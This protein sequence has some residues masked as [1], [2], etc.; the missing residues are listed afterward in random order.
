MADSAYDL[1]DGIDGVG[2]CA[3][4]LD[5][6]PPVVVSRTAAADM[7]D[8]LGRAAGSDCLSQST[9][10]VEGHRG[11]AFLLG[12]EFSPVEIGAGDLAVEVELRLECPDSPFGPLGVRYLF[13]GESKLTVNANASSECDEKVTVAAPYHRMLE[14]IHDEHVLLG[15]LMM[16]GHPV[17]SEIH[18]LGYLEGWISAASTASRSARSKL[19]GYAAAR[20]NEG[21]VELLDELD[22]VIDT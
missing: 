13:D 18:T 4:D 5:I 11:D 16:E 2:I 7:A 12:P 15:H 9:F 22:E 10:L 8:M 6:E 19:L 14:W 3:P 21:F 17:Q 20:R 1:F